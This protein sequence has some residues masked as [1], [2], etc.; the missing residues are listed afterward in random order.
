M[1]ITDAIDWAAPSEFFEAARVGSSQ[2]LHRRRMT[3]KA[4]IS[5]F[6]A[7]PAD[8]QPGAGVGLIE[9]IEISDGVTLGW[10]AAEQCRELGNLMAD[11]EQPDQQR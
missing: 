8:L 6:M 3:L 4:A 1:T 2:M 7:L 9:P 11:S 10:L 5:R